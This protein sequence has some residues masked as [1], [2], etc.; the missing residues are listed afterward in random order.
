ME[1]AFTYLIIIVNSIISYRAYIAFRDNINTEKYLFTPN[2]LS[3]GLNIEG[4]ILSNFSHA[5]FTHFLFNMITLYYFGRVVEILNGSIAFLIVYI[6]SG[7]ASHALVYYLKKD[8]IGYRS[9]GASGAIS[10][11]LFASIVLLPQM[12]ISFLFIPIPIPSPVYAVLYVAMSFYFMGSGN[13][14][15]EAH[16]GGALAGFL[17]GGYLAKG[18][19]NLI[20]EFQRILSLAS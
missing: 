20:L 13:I 7:I 3:R 11:I 12:K 15:H 4:S 19:G 14:S 1:S 17:M 16:L 8:D 18:Y 2:K 9:L 6:V 5:D 10:G